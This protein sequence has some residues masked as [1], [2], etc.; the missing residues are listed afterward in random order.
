MKM[1]RGTVRYLG[2]VLIF[3]WVE[4]D[5]PTCCIYWDFGVGFFDQEIVAISC[6]AQVVPQ[7]IELNDAPYPN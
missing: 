4:N 7:R 2:E 1:M 5:T 3:L 6:H